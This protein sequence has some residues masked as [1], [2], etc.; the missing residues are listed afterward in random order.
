MDVVIVCG[1]RSVCMRE[2]PEYRPKPQVEGCVS[3]VFLVFGRSATSSTAVTARSWKTNRLSGSRRRV[4]LW[5]TSTKA[6][7]SRWTPAATTST[8]T[9]S[10]RTAT[11]LGRCGNG[12]R[13]GPARQAHLCQGHTGFKTSRLTMLV[14]RPAANDTGYLLA[15]PPNP[16]RE[17]VGRHG[18]ADMSVAGVPVFIPHKDSDA[19]T[20]C[21]R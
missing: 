15:L 8:P 13:Q 20:I 14:H 18:E 4:S 3:A 16:L 11:P 17:L 2:E 12:D 19:I 7:S 9:N 21:V 6:F 1:G 5:P 10:G